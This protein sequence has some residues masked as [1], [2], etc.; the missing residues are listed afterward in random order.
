MNVTKVVKR[1]GKIKQYKK[2]ED[3]DP[4]VIT[5]TQKILVS[6]LVGRIDEDE[7]ILHINE[8]TIDISNI[9]S[10]ILPVLWIEISMF[11]PDEA[12][13]KLQHWLELDEK[14]CKTYQMNPIRPGHGWSRVVT[15]CNY[16]N[17]LCGNVDK[18]KEKIIARLRRDL[19]R[20]Y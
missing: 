8:K 15:A 12:N 3:L 4:K 7:I 9:I 16:F 6:N 18:N 10:D 17:S 1:L 13:V 19:T 5:L 14:S 20:K 11:S 2:Y